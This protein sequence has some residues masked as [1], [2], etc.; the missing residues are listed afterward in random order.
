MAVG[1]TDPVA[2]VGDDYAFDDFDAPGYHL[3]TLREAAAALRLSGRAVFRL[4]NLGQLRTIKLGDRT[5]VPVSEVRRLVGETPVFTE[6]TSVPELLTLAE[7]AEL[8]RISG[9]HLRRV[10][11]IGRVRTVHLGR[12]VLVPRR[13]VHRLIDEALDDRPR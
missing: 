13:E 3:L 6:P 9:R 5:L 10:R 8:L 2:S 4:R 12:R 1:E 7:A 11:L